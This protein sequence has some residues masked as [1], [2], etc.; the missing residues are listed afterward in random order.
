MNNVPRPSNLSL[1]PEQDR[2]EERLPAT[3]ELD[4]QLFFV[5]TVLIIVAILVI[6][7]KRVCFDGRCRSNSSSS[8]ANSVDD[9]A[10]HATAT[11]EAPAET[12]SSAQAFE[13]AT[14]SGEEGV[15]KIGR[16]VSS[17]LDL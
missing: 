5:E 17:E 9:D 10:T 1:L 11:V 3:V 8:D 16:P 7:A 13:S 6:I 4:L 2:D 15:H 12:F 14:G